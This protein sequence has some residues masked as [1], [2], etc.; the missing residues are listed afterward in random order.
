[1]RVLLDTNILL[2][3]LFTRGVCERVLDLCWTRAPAMTVVASEQILAEFFANA[4]AKFG[5]P[6][7][8]VIETIHR[9]RLRMEIAEPVD[10][11]V[12]ECRDPSDL[13]ILGAAL[14]GAV[15]FLV[16]GDGDLLALGSFRGIEIVSPRQFYDRIA[17]L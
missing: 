11:G 3:G 1:M 17:A 4:T 7:E 9:L 6:P 13:P 5:A 8:K 14:A 15:E 12:T 2:A 16:T 10:V